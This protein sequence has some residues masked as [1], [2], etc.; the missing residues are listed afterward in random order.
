MKNRKSSA[1]RAPFAGQST[2]RWIGV[3]LLAAMLLPLV[4]CESIE[5]FTGLRTR[6]DKVPI[7]GISASLVPGPALAPGKS[8]DLVVTAT[9]TDGK[10]YVTSGAGKGK[11][12]FDAFTYDS[13]LLT[14]NKKGAVSLPEDPR[15]SENQ[16]PHLLIT[17]LGHADIHTDLTVPIRYDV[18]YQAIDTAAAGSAGADGF[19]GSDGLAG[20]MGSIDLNNPS[21]GGNGGNGGNGSDGSDGGPGSPGPHLELAVTIK[22]GASPVLLEARVSGFGADRFFLIDPQGGTLSVAANGGPGG[23]GGSGGRAGSGGAGG[24]GSPNGQNGVDGRPGRDGLA[25]SPGKAGTITLTVDPAAQPYLAS[26]LPTTMSG[27]RAKGLAPQIIVAP[28]AALW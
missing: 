2:A 27:N 18:A 8:A 20:S 4:G 1:V 10:S 21:A 3:W 12:L 28:V 16:T 14:V 24:S 6:L 25:G 11:V 26:L 5:I 19:N 13:A 23:G 22:P 9:A 7:T 15:L 17:P